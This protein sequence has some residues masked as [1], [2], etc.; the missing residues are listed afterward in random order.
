MP[1]AGF[2][3]FEDCVADAKRKDVD[4]PEAYCGSIQAKVEGAKE[5][6]LVTDFKETCDCRNAVT[7]VGTKELDGRPAPVR[8]IRFIGVTDEESNKHRFPRQVMDQMVRDAKAHFV[9]PFHPNSV[10]EIDVRQL[11]QL[12]QLA[13]QR[14]MAVDPI[15]IRDMHHT[16]FQGT[17]MGRVLSIANKYAPFVDKTT[18]KMRQKMYMDVVAEVFDEKAIQLLDRGMLNKF[19]I[20]F[21]HRYDLVDGVKISTYSVVDH[22]GGVDVPADPDALLVEA[23]EESK[24]IPLSD[25]IQAKILSGLNQDEAEKA[26]D[27]EVK[28]MGFEQARKDSVFSQS[29]EPE[30]SDGNEASRDCV[31]SLVAQ[32]VTQEDAEA[33][34][35]GKS[36]S[37][38]RSETVT[39]TPETSPSSEPRMIDGKTLL[40]L[41]EDKD[42]SY[43]TKEAIVGLE[44]EMKSQRAFIGQLHEALKQ[45]DEQLQ[46]LLE[47][48]K[49]SEV[50]A[51]IGVLVEAGYLSPAA[52]EAAF[53]HAYSLPSPEH[54]AA[55]YDTFEGR[56]VDFGEK[57]SQSS[58]Q[59]EEGRKSVEDAAQE[60]FG[61]WGVKALQPKMKKPAGG[62]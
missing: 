2:Q 58:F 21:K 56:N 6:E 31:A 60:I 54:R 26:C 27:K 28:T 12:E 49:E 55:F 61:E 5:A 15:P 7:E 62:R 40:A 3:T 29:G 34:C 48:R 1:F 36:T 25:C 20:G 10:A 44:T 32:G 42:V 13:K 18:G 52:K 35:R 9:L 11:P 37:T 57:S 19:S 51:E 50:M 30:A 4:N 53:N 17:K 22:F 24:T 43:E 39:V 46:Q 8:I 45:R 14:G 33:A 47:E 59:T 23:K 16:K 41:L 38:D